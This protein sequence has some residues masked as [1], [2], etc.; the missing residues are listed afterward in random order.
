MG[1][2]EQG[3]EDDNMKHLLA[4]IELPRGMSANEVLRMI[5]DDGDGALQP[6]EF[7]KTF[8][9]LIDNNPFQQNCM[10]HMQLNELK[11]IS[12]TGFQ[13]VHQRLDAL[14]HTVKQIAD[15]V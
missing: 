7:V 14:A 13:E 4:Q 8:F 11:F 5:D 9:R 15:V 6:H 3:M 1:E 12:R 10:V 2:L